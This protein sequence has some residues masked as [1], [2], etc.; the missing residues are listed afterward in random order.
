M[1]ALRRQVIGFQM[2]GVGMA[3]FSDKA[4]AMA[5]VGIYN[6]GIHLEQVLKPILLTHWKITEITGLSD[7]AASARDD[8]IAH[9]ARLER[10]AGKLGEPPR[11]PSRAA[12][13]VS[14]RAGSPRMRGARTHPTAVPRRQP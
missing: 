10:V 13:R 12:R 2:P 6:L 14:P 7:E 3:G 8:V 1:L 11:P 9:L 5:R 4:R